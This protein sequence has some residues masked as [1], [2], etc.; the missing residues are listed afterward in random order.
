MCISTESTFI[1]RDKTH[2]LT[3]ISWELQSVMQKDDHSFFLF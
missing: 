1:R 2:E 3:D